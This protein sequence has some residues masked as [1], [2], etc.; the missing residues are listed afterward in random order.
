MDRL[1]RVSVHA[2]FRLSPSQ[3]EGGEQLGA[4]RAGSS[5]GYLSEEL[6]NTFPSSQSPESSANE[7][8]IRG[9]FP[10]TS[11]AA[12]PPPQSS[13]SSVSWQIPEHYRAHWERVPEPLK[14]IPISM[15]GF[16]ATC[17]TPREEHIGR[18]YSESKCFGLLSQ[19][20]P[21]RLAAPHHGPSYCFMEKCYSDIP[22]RSLKALYF[23]DTVKKIL[24]SQDRNPYVFPTDNI[25]VI[26]CRKNKKVITGLY[27]RCD[28]DTERGG[29]AEAYPVSQGGRFDIRRLLD[30]RGFEQPEESRCPV[31]DILIRHAF[32]GAEYKNSK[33][34]TCHQNFSI[35]FV[36]PT[37]NFSMWLYIF[38]SI[39]CPPKISSP[40]Y[41]SQMDLYLSMR[42]TLEE[43]LNHEL[44]VNLGVQTQDFGQWND[45]RFNSGGSLG[46]N[47]ILSQFLIPP[48]ICHIIAS[49][50]PEATGV[51]IIGSPL[52]DFRGDD[53]R[54]A[55]Y[56]QYMHRNIT[57][58]Q[59]ADERNLTILER[60]S[61]TKDKSTFEDARLEAVGGWPLLVSEQGEIQ[62]FGIP[63]FPLVMRFTTRN[64]LCKNYDTWFAY[65]GGKDALPMIVRA[66]LR[67]FCSV[68]D[69][70]SHEFPDISHF[71]TDTREADAVTLDE[72]YF[73]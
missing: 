8:R 69:E 62:A 36:T 71:L 13:S 63:P 72:T 6:D 19:N 22:D 45:Y 34:Q 2:D 3:D 20:S 65:I 31:S 4:A 54:A 26:H 21:E 24:E 40:H 61:Q 58:I 29:A 39:L 17:M 73:R 66:L 53:L 15:H 60:Y 14:H 25:G 51:R 41:Q 38:E 7:A 64:A 5:S 55:D 70:S 42:T 43:I 35:V 27:S 47:T 23:F 67:S 30:A 10:N 56:I 52:M 57:A 32:T 11:P 59:R 46:V 49:D 1:T 33:G 37:A 28:R 50:E 12:L 18:M 16:Q 44:V 68:Q 9:L 48:K